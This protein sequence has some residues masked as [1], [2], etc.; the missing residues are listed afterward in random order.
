MGNGDEMTD[1]NFVYW[2]QGYLDSICRS[3]D[4]NISLSVEQT[5]IIRRHLKSVVARR[6]ARIHRGLRGEKTKLV[7]EVE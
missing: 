5:S 3:E 6:L 2:L 7:G 4:D 1:K